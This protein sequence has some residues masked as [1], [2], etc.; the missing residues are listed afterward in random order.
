MIALVIGFTAALGL[1]ALGLGVCVLGPPLLVRPTAM[2]PGRVHSLGS[3]M[4]VSQSLRRK[5]A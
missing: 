4:K 2:P 1:L 3:S 5:P